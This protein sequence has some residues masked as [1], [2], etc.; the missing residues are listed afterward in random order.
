M[1]KSQYK[2]MLIVQSYSSIPYNWDDVYVPLVFF[3]INPIN[4]YNS[5]DTNHI[6]TLSFTNISTS[7]VRSHRDEQVTLFLTLVYSKT[8]IN[9]FGGNKKQNQSEGIT[10]QPIPV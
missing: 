8:A 3:M 9:L 4:P 5:L 10:T 6:Y 1:N 7:N 2:L